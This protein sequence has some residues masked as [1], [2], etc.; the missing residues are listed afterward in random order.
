MGLDIY[1]L[2]KV[3]VGAGCGSRWLKIEGTVDIRKNGKA[4]PVELN[5]IWEITECVGYWR[6]FAP[7]HQ[8]MLENALSGE[9]DCL[10]HVISQEVISKM[11]V[12]CKKI[13]SAEKDW[14]VPAKEVFP[15]LHFEKADPDQLENFLSE[16][17]YTYQ[18][19]LDLPDESPD[20]VYC[21][22]AS[23]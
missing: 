6:K 17:R 16:I 13:I 7:L 23:W 22:K 1:L 12:D 10:E 4:V 8:W 14:I 19:L 2:R 5:R 11:K 9:N 18:I 3:Y 15:Y 21:Y 20:A